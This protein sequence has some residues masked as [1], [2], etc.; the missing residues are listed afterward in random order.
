MPKKK[1]VQLCAQEFRKDADSL[2]EFCRAAKKGLSDEHVDLVYDMAVIR[3]YADFE[4]MILGTLTGAINNDLSQLG[5]KTSI[6][7]PKHL[8]AD[9]CEFLIVGTGY[10]NF[11]GRSGLIGEMRKYVPKDHYSVEAV[12]NKDYMDAINRLCALR[13]FAAHNSKVAK[14]EAKKAV[15]QKSIKSAGTWLKRGSR[16]RSLV[17]NL[18]SLSKNIQQQAPY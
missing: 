8:N 7:F 1:S 16:F 17:E 12:K 9:V 6:E 2:L 18:K 13:N 3:L 14:N 4:R 11:R 5:C 15:G 10:F